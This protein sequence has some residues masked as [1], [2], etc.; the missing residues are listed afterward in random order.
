ML[1]TNS[2]PKR[3]L[4]ATPVITTET[5]TTFCEGGRVILTAPVATG[6]HWFKDGLAINNAT[7]QTYTATTSGKYSV[8]VTNQSGCSSPISA[9]VIV[10]VNALPATPVITTE[11]STTFCE[12]GSVILTAPA[13]TGYQWFLNGPAK[14]QATNN[15]KKQKK[16]CK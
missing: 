8:L 15:N 11:T 6:Y 9:E 10:V 12:G 3:P 16:K 13:A 7:S 4:P 5:A 14:K 1:F 2:Y